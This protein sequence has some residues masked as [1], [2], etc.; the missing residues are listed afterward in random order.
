MIL[1]NISVKY[2]DGDGTTFAVQSADITL[3]DRGRTLRTGVP[4]PCSIS[5]PVRL[6]MTRKGWKT[7][8]KLTKPAYVPR[9]LRRIKK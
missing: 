2:P 5:I 4:S 9:K 7:L 1:T 8:I 3:E 6:K